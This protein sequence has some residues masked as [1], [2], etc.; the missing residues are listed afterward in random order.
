MV[1]YQILRTSIIRIVWQRV[2]RIA[3]EIL[4]SYIYPTFCCRLKV[5]EHTRC[6]NVSVEMVRMAE[7][8]DHE[9]T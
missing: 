1:Q 2:M 6:I 4:G 8:R 5:N 3:D 9:K 7:S